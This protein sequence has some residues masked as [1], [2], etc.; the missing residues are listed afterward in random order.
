MALAALYMSETDQFQAQLVVASCCS[1]LQVPIG[2][3]P[4]FTKFTVPLQK[5]GGSEGDDAPEVLSECGCVLSF[6]AFDT[7]CFVGHLC[8]YS[9]ASKAIV[10]DG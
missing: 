7:A 8:V 6:Y 3:I 1:N 5:H 2:A 4:N 10:V 9:T